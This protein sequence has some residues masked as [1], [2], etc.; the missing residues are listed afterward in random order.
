[1]IGYARL[2]LKVLSASTVSNVEQH[3]VFTQLQT[4]QTMHNL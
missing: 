4:Q 1:M 2:R 3:V